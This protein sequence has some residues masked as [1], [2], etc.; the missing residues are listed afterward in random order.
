MIYYKQI[1]VIVLPAAPANP[2][3]D[4]NPNTLKYDTRYCVKIM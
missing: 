3:L 4:K 2:H 1:S